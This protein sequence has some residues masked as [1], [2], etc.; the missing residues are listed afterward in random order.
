MCELEKDEQ[1]EILNFI[2]KNKFIF[3]YSK[4]DKEKDKNYLKLNFT[5]LKLSGQ[6]IMNKYGY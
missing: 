4:E 2:A 3:D 1:Q 5:E 6:K